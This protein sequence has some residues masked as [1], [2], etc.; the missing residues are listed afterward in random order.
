MHNA[1]QDL[2][3]TGQKLQDQDGSEPEPSKASKGASEGA[4]DAG[5]ASLYRGPEEAGPTVRSPA[6]VTPNC[7]RSPR[8]SASR[9]K[10]DRKSRTNKDK[11]SSSRFQGRIIDV[12]DFDGSDYAEPAKRRRLGQDSSERQVVQ[13]DQLQ[14]VLEESAE[15]AAK[16]SSGS[17][18][19]QRSQRSSQGKKLQR[20]V[21]PQQGSNDGRVARRARLLLSQRFLSQHLSQLSQCLSQRM[22]SSRQGRQGQGRQAACRG[23]GR[24]RGWNL[25][26]PVQQ[27]PPL[28]AQ[29][30]QPAQPLQPAKQV[31]GAPEPPGLAS[32]AP[33]RPDVLFTGFARSDLHNLRSMVNCLGGLAV[34]SLTGGRRSNVRLIVQS[35]RSE[36]SEER[37]V[38]AMRSVKYME[39]VL[40]GAW[41]LSP[42]WV[43]ASMRAGHWL[44]EAR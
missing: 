35:T 20:V 34:S 42:E 5:A 26:R 18:R 38:A 13:S 8:T 32:A 17:Q 29:P 39:G 44:P 28:P 2:P 22:A 12:T 25:A 14:L 41:V 31:S 30:A 4:S 6:G 27:S 43:H 16:E 23:A 19:S 7:A 33:E 40:A 9:G 24:R 3:A 1:L 10:A 21:K 37:Q 11:G 36:R 15:A